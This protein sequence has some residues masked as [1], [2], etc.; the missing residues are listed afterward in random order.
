MFICIYLSIYLC[1]YICIVRH[2]INKC[3]RVLIHWT[4]FDFAMHH[5]F[6]KHHHVQII[7]TTSIFYLQWATRSLCMLLTLL[8]Q[9]KPA[10]YSYIELSYVSAKLYRSNVDWRC[11]VQGV[12]CRG[13]RQLELH[14]IMQLTSS[15]VHVHTYAV[16]VADIAAREG[17]PHNMLHSSSYSYMLCLLAQLKEYRCFPVSKS[18]T[19]VVDLLK[20]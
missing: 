7:E 17:S 20:V 18:Q 15:Y 11:I 10:N 14:A 12:I 2:S 9:A 5:R 6:R 3:P 13:P 19:P 4:A 8:G 1:L 16:G